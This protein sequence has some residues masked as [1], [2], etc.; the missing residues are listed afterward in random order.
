MEV[1]HTWF[2]QTDGTL[3]A[4]G[5]KGRWAR[6][7]T[8]VLGL[9]RQCSL[10]PLRPLGTPPSP[11]QAPGQPH[12]H[13][14]AMSSTL[15]LAFSPR[16]EPP[17]LCWEQES[18]L[19]AR[20]GRSR[21]ETLPPAPRVFCQSAPVASLPCVSWRRRQSPTPQVSTGKVLGPHFPLC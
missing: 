11:A 12:C 3:A 17:R 16:S 7:G 8:G 15:G 9:G 18:A 6:R 2:S 4:T 5:P 20:A 1:F 13:L 19:F 10:S 21:Q 14:P